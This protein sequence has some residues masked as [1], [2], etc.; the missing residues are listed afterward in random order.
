MI[1]THGGFIGE[2]INVINSFIAAK[3]GSPHKDKF[4]NNSKNTCVNIFALKQDISNPVSSSG[5]PNVTFEITLLNDASHI[6][7]TIA[8]LTQDDNKVKN[9]K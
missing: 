1:V 7:E 9:Q 8:P 4:S 3:N 6:E 2:F 5:Q